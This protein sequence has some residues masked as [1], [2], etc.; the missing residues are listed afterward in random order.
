MLLVIGHARAILSVLFLF[1]WQVRIKRHLK[2]IAM[3]A[4]QFTII[5]FLL[6]RLIA[7]ALATETDGHVAELYRLRMRFDFVHPIGNVRFIPSGKL[8]TTPTWHGKPCR[9]LVTE[10]DSCFS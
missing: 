2:S 8:R 1:R 3:R 5:L 9:D 10:A 7:Q 4:S 6:F